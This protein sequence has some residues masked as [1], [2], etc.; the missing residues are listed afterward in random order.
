MALSR[1]HSDGKLLFGE[2]FCL[3]SRAYTQLGLAWHTPITLLMLHTGLDL[4]P[5]AHCL[6]TL[7]GLVGH[8]TITHCWD[9]SSG[10]SHSHTLKPP[11][12]FELEG[13]GSDAVVCPVVAPLLWDQSSQPLPWE[14]QSCPHHCHLQ[15]ITRSRLNAARRSGVCAAIT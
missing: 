4:L 14:P 10:T 15:N 3:A 12:L 8:G 11:P 9:N 6:G 13:Q 2:A 7:T 5:V 1:P